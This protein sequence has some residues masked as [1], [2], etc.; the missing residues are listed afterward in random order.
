MLRYFLFLDHNLKIPS[1]DR[2]RDKYNGNH[3]RLKAKLDKCRI[4]KQI[5]RIIYATRSFSLCRFKM[6][7]VG[8]D[9]TRYI[10]VCQRFL[11]LQK[12]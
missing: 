4:E 2:S 7:N 5:S 12:V 6:I 10:G 8:S 1:R 9:L 3:C 11:F